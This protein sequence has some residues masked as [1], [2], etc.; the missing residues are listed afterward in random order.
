MPKS[1]IYKI[2]Q[3]VVN[4]SYGEKSKREARIKE[5]LSF[6]F[7]SS[8]TVD[9]IYH[10]YLWHK[11][12][13][14]GEIALMISGRFDYKNA[15]VNLNEAQKKIEHLK[16]INQNGMV[17][18]VSHYGNWEFL[19]QFFAINGLSG[20]LVA[21]SHKKNRLIDEK[22]IQPYRR[23]FGH[24]V[25]KREGALR[26][27]AK[28]LR[29]KEGVGMHI[30]QMIPPPNGVEVEFFGK[31]VYASK[32]M[33]KLKLK[34]NPLV[35][36]IFAKRVGRGEFEVIIKEP[37]EFIAEDIDKIEDKI[38]KITQKYTEI[39]EN[40]IISSPEQWAWEYKRWR[41]P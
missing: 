22:I 20:T 18:L 31:S 25:I 14:F 36:P 33:A 4:L 8:K 12:S 28:I 35:V 16:S 34:F 29:A 13:F 10:D 5:H 38:A 11:A 41:R 26:A 24:R 2:S 1:L 9:E 6:A 27:I 23:A 32:S 40:Q 37:V 30:D 7:D 19:A 3:L 17:F 39:L 21:K 15:V